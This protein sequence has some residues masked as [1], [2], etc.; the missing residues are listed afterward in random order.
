MFI[1]ENDRV[2]LF[3]TK[4]FKPLDFVLLNLPKLVTIFA[5][6]LY[7]T[8]DAFTTNLGF[9]IFDIGNIPSIFH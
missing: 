4:D 3:V 1:Y 8:L 7:L 9:H 2:G 5:T 6:S